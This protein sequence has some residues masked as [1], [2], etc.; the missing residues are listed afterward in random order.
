MDKTQTLKTA[1]VVKDSDIKFNVDKPRQSSG[2][3]ALKFFVYLLT[4]LVILVL[5]SLIVFVIVKSTKIFQTE[6]FFKFIFTDRWKPGSDQD[7]QDGLAYFGIG[8]IIASTI[9]M[10]V[11]SLLIA[12]PI[13]IFS[14]LF[15]SEYMSHKVQK[16]C[17]NIIKLLAGVPSVVFGLFALNQVGPL[18]MLMGASTPTNLMVASFTLAFM[19]LPTMISLSYNAIQSVPTS[20]RFASL[21]LGIT[22]EQTTFNVVRRSATPKI[23]SAI[24]MG[25]ARVIG[26]TMAVILIAGNA[27]SGLD[28]HHG[29]GGFVFSPIKTLA[30]TIGLEMLENA[31]SLHESALFA[32]GLVLFILMTIINL[33]VMLMSNLD[34]YK[35]HAARKKVKRMNKLLALR[36]KGI[37]E[38][39]TTPEP[40]DKY[41]SNELTYYVKF[42]TTSRTRQKVG[43]Q[44]AMFFMISST[45]LIMAF[46]FWIFGVVIV[47]GLM[48]LKFIDAFVSVN[49]QAG[50]FAA[51]FTTILLIIATLVLA[52]PLALATALYLNQYARPKAFSTKCIRFIINLLA[53]T[54]SIVFGIFGLSVFILLFKMP[55]SILAS[56]LTMAIV[57][58]PMLTVNF[59]DAIS[60][61]PPAYMEAAASLGQTKAEIIFKIILPSAK[62]RLVTGGILAVAKIIGETAPIYL[63]LG[64]AIRMPAEGFMASGATL[65]TAIYMLASEG[66]GGDA[67]SIAFL[68]SL[69]TMLLV[70]VLNRVSYSLST[71]GDEQHLSIKERARM[72]WS[73]VTHYH[74]WKRIDGI[75]TENK[76]KL[77]QMNDPAVREEH[78]RQKA[79][80]REMQRILKEKQKEHQEK[81]KRLR[82]EAKAKAKKKGGD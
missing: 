79:I 65:T 77:A 67:I 76:L 51:L 34:T 73:S 20:Y 64:T 31:G 18:F 60:Q 16:F 28:V 13:T 53:S 47:R 50:I 27:A 30:G 10:L 32:I 61:V 38:E 24:I 39:E 54:P 82:Q 75:I 4:T 15:I 43:T 7:Y 68:F 5:L 46:A 58:I 33:V 42:K 2:E 6:G 63:T 55:L 74:L 80:R 40:V 29:F 35:K 9:M 26:E 23:I 22:K 36:G 69:I 41:T 45:I 21:G 12:V 56:A 3:I 57:V 72:F 11:I 52:I 14:A 78:A 81:E 8:G 19:A 49:G 44:F 48:G 59:E 66:G 17:I 70:F 71:R 37:V 25:M 1:Q 62:E